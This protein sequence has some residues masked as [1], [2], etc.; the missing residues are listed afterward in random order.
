[1]RTTPASVAKRLVI[2]A[3]LLLA[4]CD[5]VAQQRAIDTARSRMTI[6]VFRSG[7]FSAFGHNHTI[8]APIADGVVL[9]GESPFVSLRIESRALKV[10]D[11]DLAV[12]KRAEVQK[13]MLGP[14]V[15]G[16]A[17]FPDIRF[18]SSAV[19][20]DGAAKWIVRGE[21]MLHGQTRPVTVRVEERDGLY[22]GQATLKQR[23]FGITPVSVAGGTVR[24]K[25]EVKIEFEIALSGKTP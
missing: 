4:P 12:D 15:L 14:D 2:A 8:E 24:V 7:F 16:V 23:D 20:K 5:A 17:R 19:Q 21:L 11:P 22:R 18:Q 3:W 13:T 6:R 10:L 9:S 25:D 1:V